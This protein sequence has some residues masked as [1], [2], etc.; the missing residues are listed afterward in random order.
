[1]NIIRDE[2]TFGIM[3]IPLFVDWNIRR[4]NFKDCK[5]RP[6]TIIT[7]AGC[8]NFGLCENHYQ[9]ANVEGGAILSLEWNNFDAFREDNP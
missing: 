7:D 6:N 5:E 1:M 2:E 4:C 9:M 8:S 3:M